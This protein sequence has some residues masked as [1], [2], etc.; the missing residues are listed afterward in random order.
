MHVD[1]TSTSNRGLPQ[2]NDATTLL[3]HL[4]YHFD[5][6]EYADC[7]LGI[8]I[9]NDVKHIKLHA[10]VIGQSHLLRAMLSSAPVTAESSIKHLE[11]RIL[12]ELGG[13]YASVAA[14]SAALLVLYGADAYAMLANL[15]D[16]TDPSDSSKLDHAIAYLF[17]G[18]L[19][20]IRDV[21]R[22]GL[23]AI[24]TN[25]SLDG[26]CKA[27]EFALN[28]GHPQLTTESGTTPVDQRDAYV[29]YLVSQRTDDSNEHIVNTVFQFMVNNFP[30][31]F[32]LDTAVPSRMSLGAPK[33]HAGFPPIEG[34]STVIPLGTARFSNGVPPSRR[35]SVFSEIL[36]S[37]EYRN[38][39]TLFGA[40]QDL[41]PS[42]AMDE[43]WEQREVRFADEEAD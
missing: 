28:C 34:L 39:S 23:D 40:V 43:V 1:S 19:L 12:D 42:E 24:S 25:L 16:E 31:P 3:E 33:N 22:A 6:P 10:I 35:C 36:L 27:L 21:Q 18:N 4:L 37:L 20:A 8:H 38:V 14:F 26:L 5:A 2:T 29:S 9:G 30:V 41:L 15:Y 13:K 32:V 17:A 7:Q 11:F